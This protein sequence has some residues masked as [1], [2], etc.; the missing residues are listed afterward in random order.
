MCSLWPTARLESSSTHARLMP[1]VLLT[2]SPMIIKFSISIVSTADWTRSRG[3]RTRFVVRKMSRMRSWGA[4]R[5][6]SFK[7]R[8]VPEHRPTPIS[9]SPQTITV[10]MKCK[11]EEML[12]ATLD[13]TQTNRLSRQ[14]PWS[15]WLCAPLTR[16]WLST[17]SSSL[18][19]ACVVSKDSNTWPCC[20]T[21][22][23]M[24]I[25]LPRTLFRSSRLPTTWQLTHLHLPLTTTTENIEVPL[26]KHS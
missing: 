23:R 13:A 15:I 2:I 14:W 17:Y 18:M 8:E 7:R 22:T 12:S 20:C 3:T 9:S 1:K 5:S 24:L 21:R 11:R 6:A 10:S 16:S 26:H 4:S 19:R 25:L